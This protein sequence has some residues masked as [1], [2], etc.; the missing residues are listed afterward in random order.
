[1]RCAVFSVVLYV[2]LFSVVLYVS[3]FSVVLC[4]FSVVLCLSSPSSLPHYYPF[5]A[6]IG[7]A[8]NLLGGRFV[9]PAFILTGH[10]GPR[11]A[12][13][14]YCS[15]INTPPGRFRKTAVCQWP[16]INQ[17]KHCKRRIVRSVRGGVV[18]SV[19]R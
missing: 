18:R 16:D 8:D 3:L 19:R 17:G 6:S 14:S 4:L 9:V 13:L 1:M 10:G 7:D 15:H 5:R 2:S 11:Y 12:G